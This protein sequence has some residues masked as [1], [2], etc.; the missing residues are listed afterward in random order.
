MR[1]TKRRVET[2]I[3]PSLINNYN[4]TVDKKQINRHIFYVPLKSDFSSGVA[5]YKK[6]MSIKPIL[7]YSVTDS[8]ES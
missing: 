7:L 2:Y 3:P 6:R 5:P 8:A 1:N 4:N